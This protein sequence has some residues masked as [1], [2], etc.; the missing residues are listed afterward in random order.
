M[1][2]TEKQAGR[3]AES[4]VTLLTAYLRRKSLDLGFSGP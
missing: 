1:Q 4:L 2:E 3:V